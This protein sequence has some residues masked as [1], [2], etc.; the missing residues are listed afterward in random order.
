MSISPHRYP[1]ITA[2][3]CNLNEE[4]NLPHVLPGKP[5]VSE[6]FVVDGYSHHRDQR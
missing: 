6:A 3:I 2:L 1:K 4:Q 5:W